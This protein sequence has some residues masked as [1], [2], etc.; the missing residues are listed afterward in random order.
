M[1]VV[2]LLFIGWF[3][4][5]P[6]SHFSNFGK[7][8]SVGCFLT[9]ISFLCIVLHKNSKTLS[10]LANASLPFQP[11]PTQSDFS[12][13]P[14]IKTAQQGHHWSPDA[15]LNSQ[16]L[17]GAWIRSSLPPLWLAFLTWLSTVSWFS[18]YI[19]GCSSVSFS[20][21]SS[22]SQPLNSGLYLKAQTWL[23]TTL[24]LHPLSSEPRGFKYHL[25]FCLICALKSPSLLLWHKD[26]LHFSLL[27]YNPL[28]VNLGTRGVWNLDCSRLKKG[29]V[30]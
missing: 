8:P 18:S 17:T 16:L 25:C 10:I 5:K 19:T 21:S 22:S 20:V 7:M 11:K 12:L 1:W 14:S 24:F 28:S 6:I 27:V 23:S 29:D 15:N 13:H 26:S 9:A 30:I 4:G 2:F 3:Q